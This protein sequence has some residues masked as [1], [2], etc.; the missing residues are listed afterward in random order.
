MI[1]SDSRKFIFI[2]NPKVGGMSFRT[3]LKQHDTTDEFFLEWVP[4]PQIGRTLDRAHLTLEQLRTHHR[5]VYDLMDDYFT[6]GFTRDP[7]QRFCSALSQ[8]LKLTTTLIRAA[9]MGD[10]DCFYSVANQVTRHVFD[11]AAMDAEVKLIHFRRQSDFFYIDGAR[12]IEAVAKIEEPETWDPRAV[13]LLGGTEV[14]RLNKTDQVR[15]GGEGYEI[16]R[17]DRESL[18]RINAFYADDFA[19]FGYAQR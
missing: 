1:V 19:R 16:D 17:L 12:R 14:K 7:Y 11:E 8:H 4:Y 2:H 13:D 9:V 10:E 5:D 15:D 6:F 3:I 18:D